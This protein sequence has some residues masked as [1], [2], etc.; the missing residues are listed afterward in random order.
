ME[1]YNPRLKDISKKIITNAYENTKKF[2]KPSKE[3]MMEAAR[4][5]VGFPFLINAA[6][7][8]IPSIVRCC[9]EESPS[10]EE[11]MSFSDKLAI[12]AVYINTLGLAYGHIAAYVEACENGYEVLAIPAITNIASGIYEMGKK[13]KK[14]LIKEH[15]DRNLESKIKE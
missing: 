8:M 6:P 4:V 13:A 9:R 15:W 11:K 1:N 2:L 3:G 10:S 14:D 12:G 5:V 7:Y